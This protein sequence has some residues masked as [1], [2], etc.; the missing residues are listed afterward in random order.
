VIHD[1]DDDDLLRPQIDLLYS[2]LLMRM[3][4]NSDHWRNDDMQWDIE[5]GTFHGLDPLDS[6][7]S[8]LTS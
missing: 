7:N 6:C 8:K 1:D 5:V 2:L 3:M 4:M